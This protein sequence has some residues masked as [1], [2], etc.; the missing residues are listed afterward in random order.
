MTQGLRVQA[1]EVCTPACAP[2]QRAAEP[3]GVLGDVWGPGWLGREVVRVKALR[4]SGCHVERFAGARGR[5]VPV[6][7]AGA[8]GSEFQ[9][10][11][12][13]LWGSGWL[14]REVKR[15]QA[16]HGVR[17]YPR[18]AGIQP[19]CRHLTEVQRWRALGPYS[20]KPSALNN[21]APRTAITCVRMRMVR[22][23]IS[24]PP[25]SFLNPAHTKLRP[26]DKF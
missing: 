6:V 18:G 24:F 25:F 23:C 8:L 9:W 11:V 16:F 20:A 5:R 12:P 22:R 21:C 7:C 17:A 2:V 14:D 19:R 13:K 1:L 3:T 10:C 4:C 15:V 26:H